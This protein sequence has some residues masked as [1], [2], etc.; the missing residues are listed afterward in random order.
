M[1]GCD[2][3]VQGVGSVGERVS[4]GVVAKPM[5]AVGVLRPDRRDVRRR[6]TTALRLA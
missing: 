4:T 2:T 6:P 1:F 5:R 3:S